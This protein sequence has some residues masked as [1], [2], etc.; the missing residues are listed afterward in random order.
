MCSDKNFTQCSDCQARRLKRAE[1]PQSVLEQPFPRTYIYGFISPKKHSPL[2]KPSVSYWLSA[3]N[4]VKVWKSNHS[5]L[6]CKFF[7]TF[8][9]QNTSR[10]GVNA[11]NRNPSQQTRDWGGSVN[12]WE[13]NPSHSKSMK[14]NRKHALCERVNAFS[15][16]KYVYI[17]RVNSW[18]FNPS[19]Q[20]L[21]AS[22][23]F[24]DFG[25]PFFRYFLLLVYC[26]LRQLWRVDEELMRADY[27]FHATPCYCYRFFHSSG[28][29]LD[30]SGNKDYKS[31]TCFF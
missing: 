7:S 25:W 3:G 8:S 10:V 28:C 18:I 24:P 12:T 9:A 20:V 11:W 26:F 14:I 22:V 6:P 1:N 13:R 19:Q 23:I 27:T 15:G 16:I 4:C 17:R 29:I 30:S 5:R 2:H 31:R 21:Q